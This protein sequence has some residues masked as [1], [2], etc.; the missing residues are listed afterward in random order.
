MT[1]ADC[2]HK[3]EC[4][5]KINGEFYRCHEKAKRDNNEHADR[6]KGI[7]KYLTFIELEPKA[8]TKVFEVR[9]KQFNSWLGNVKWYAP[10][11][12]YCFFAAD[13]IVFDAV[14]LENIQDFIK[15]LM[16]DREE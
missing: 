15:R 11:R 10:W 6:L 4:K 7:Y 13:G 12:K 14:C 16:W 9:N 3:K 5:K 2:S 8:K 1:C